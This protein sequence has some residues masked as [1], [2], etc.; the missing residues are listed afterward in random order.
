MNVDIHPATADRFADI[1]AILNPNNSSAPLC[2][3]LSIRVPN[4]EYSALAGE[5]RPARLREYC[6]HEPSPGVIAYVDGTPVGWCS[7]GPRSGMHRLTHS[8]TIPVIDDV[9]VWS[10]ICFI[11]RPPHRG[12]GL[13]GRLLDAAID[14]ARGQGVPAL[15]AYPI[16]SEAGKVGSGSAYVGTTNLFASAGFDRVAETTSKSGGAK[17][18]VMRLNL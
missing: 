3:C 1:A 6:E 7:F 15:E 18:W 5:E 4:S 10:V 14:Y 9:P 17:R 16:E 11:V 2:W 8:R 13:S 12:K